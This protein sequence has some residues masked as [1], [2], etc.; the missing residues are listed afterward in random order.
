MS[1]QVKNPKVTVLISAYNE[2][3]YIG[4]CIRSLLDQSFSRDE[5]EIIVI[6]DGSTDKTSYALSLFDKA[7]R[8]INNKQ[9]LGLPSSLNIAID[10]SN[11]DYIV[12]VDADDF[13][14]KNFLNF[15]YQFIEFNDY[16]DSIA[17]DYF[18]VDD[19]EK[20]IDRKDCLKSPIACG[21]LFKKTDLIE[22]GLYDEDFFLNEEVELR[23][24]YLE[25]FKIG[26]LELPLY[27]YRKH[28]NNMTNNKEQLEEYE[29]KFK[30]KHNLSS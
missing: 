28:K 16:Y 2:E 14:N 27:R 4:R 7:I 13:V 8:V 10:K 11:A 9:N 3:K 22:I 18:I 20:I 5:Y 29:K 12:R 24:R 15:L 25:K 26:R 23:H 30:Q 17:C 19:E 6:N 1:E 21:I